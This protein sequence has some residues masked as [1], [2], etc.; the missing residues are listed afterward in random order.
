MKLQL[1][2]WTFSW[3]DLVSF[4]S[5]GSIL[6]LHFG[7]YFFLSIEYYRPCWQ[8][9]RPSRFS[10]YCNSPF[11]RRPFNQ[12]Y[13]RISCLC[14]RFFSSSSSQLCVHTNVPT[15]ITGVLY[16]HMRLSYIIIISASMYHSKSSGGKLDRWPGL[17]GTQRFKYRLWLLE[18]KNPSVQRG[19]VR[20][21]V[22]HENT[23]PLMGVILFVG[24]NMVLYNASL[25]L[26]TCWQCIYKLLLPTISNLANY[27]WTW[28]MIEIREKCVHMNY[29]T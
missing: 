29:R 9:C 2:A 28:N 22:R 25:W 4:Q 19:T 15:W 18:Y 23:T 24:L 3:R 11:P 7:Y 17:H 5:S 14:T 21:S 27:V 26:H 16:V 12:V 8:I 1:T 20:R 6:A 10:P 13:Q